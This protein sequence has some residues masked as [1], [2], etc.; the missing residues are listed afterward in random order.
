MFKGMIRSVKGREILDSDGQRAAQAQV[1][2]ADGSIGTAGASGNNSAKAADEITAVFGPR[3]S[4]RAAGKQYELDRLLLR[5]KKERTQCTDGAVLAVSLACAQAAARSLNIP[6]YQYLGGIYANRL[7]VPL[8][9]MIASGTF[10]IM[11]A[12]LNTVSFREG[13]WKA[14]RIYQ[15]LERDTKSTEEFSKEQAAQ[16]VLQAIKETGENPQD[17]SILWEMPL[18]TV[19]VRPQKE[20][21]LSR[22]LDR[23]RHLQHG[24]LGI[25][26][27]CCADRTGETAFADLAVAVGAGWIR[28]GVPGMA[29]HAARL[30]RMIQI[31]EELK[32]MDF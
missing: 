18:N 7:P 8:Y 9:T 32:E 11:L 23:T 16:L 10:E 24:G 4:G 25:V 5:Q 28:T 21:S 2:L 26:F 15:A 13:L 20:D 6:L 31:E 19:T 27:D 30:N 3:L 29:E 1:E 12:P 14:V 17:F 22:I